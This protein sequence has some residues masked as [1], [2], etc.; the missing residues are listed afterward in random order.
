[1]GAQV[2]NSTAWT[3][4]MFAA[5]HPEFIELENW[6]PNTPDLNPADYSVSEALQQTEYHQKISQIDRLEFVLINCWIQLNQLHDRLNRA[7]NQLPKRL[8]TVIKA[9]GANNEF[10]LDL[11][12]VQMITADFFHCTFEL[13]IG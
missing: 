7:I 2:S 8:M 4:W 1:M 10:R 6:R 13:K 5:I 12:C 11:F 9:N 3:V